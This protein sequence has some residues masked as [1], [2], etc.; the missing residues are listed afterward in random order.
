MSKQR[1]VRP[2]KPNSEAAKIMK[3]DAAAEVVAAARAEGRIV[4]VA[5]GVFDLLHLGH[6]R[7]LDLARQE[8]DFLVVSITADAYVNK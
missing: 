7:H 5:H 2:G 6:V 4:A 3:I 8:G 1:S